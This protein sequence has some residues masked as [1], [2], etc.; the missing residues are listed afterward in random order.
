MRGASLEAAFGARKVFLVMSS[1]GERPRRARVLLDG[2]AIAPETAGSDVE[3]GFVTVRRER[4]YELVAL[5]GVEH[6]R[7]G[8][9]LP[10]G[11]TG[12][13]FTFG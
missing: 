12:Y 2:R 10:P 11:V 5:P 7:L 1:R 13:A 4:L 3:D 9:E 6:R 8:L